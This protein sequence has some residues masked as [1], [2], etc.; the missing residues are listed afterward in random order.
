MDAPL[1]DTVLKHQR[2]QW[3][4]G[5]GL[6]GAVVGGATACALAVVTAASGHGV[7]GWIWATAGIAGAAAAAWFCRGGAPQRGDAARAMDRHFGLKDLHGSALAFATEVPALAQG[8]A[9]ATAQRSARWLED[10]GADLPSRLPQPRRAPWILA[11][12][13]VALGAA[14]LA[15]V[16]ISPEIAR[17]TAAAAELE[18]QT[19]DLNAALTEEL[20]RLLEPEEDAAAGLDEAEARQW[21]A[22]LKPTRD[23]AEAL[24]QYAALEQRLRAAETALNQPEK[25]RLL[26]QAG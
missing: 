6:R 9:A 23:L 7:P 3:L 26:R 10:A 16:P 17:Q 2:R 11:V 4:L 8:Y 20:E 24:R 14:M 1:L 15:R 18:K 22:S 5:A 25:Q 12:V 13:A 19:T 21:V